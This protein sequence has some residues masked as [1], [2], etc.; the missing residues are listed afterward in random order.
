[1]KLPSLNFL[2]TNAGQSFVRFPLSILA[3]LAS[4][5]IGVYLVEQGYEWEDTLPYLN[6]ML[7]LGLGIPVYFCINVLVAKKQWSLQWQ[8]SLLLLATVALVLLYFTFPNSSDTLNNTL[9]YTRYII[10]NIIAHLLVAFIPYTQRHQLNGFWNYN[11]I[12]FLRFLTSILYSSVL[13][14]GLVLA[15]ASLKFLFD[16]ELHEELFAD[17]AICIFGF[18][19]TWFFVAGIPTDFD[20]LNTVDQYP[21]GLRIF[22]Q[23]ILLPLLCLYFVI[24]YGYGSKIIMLWNWPKGLVSYL[25]LCVAVL[26]IFTLLLLYPYGNIKAFDWIKKLSRGYY[27]LLVPLIVLLFIA[28]SFRLGDY[29]ITINRYIILFLG[30]WLTMVSIYF[31]IGKTDIRFI[32][33]SLSIMLFLMSFGPWGMFD[34][35]ERS[36]VNRL[37][38]ILTRANILK[39]GRIENEVIWSKNKPFVDSSKLKNSNEGLMSDSIHNEVMSIYDYLNTHH[40]FRA[41]RP[42]YVQNIDSLI[43]VSNKGKKRWERTQENEAYMESAGLKHEYIYLNNQGDFFNYSSTRDNV[44]YVEDYQYF[45]SFNIAD[46]NQKSDF[47]IE[48]DSFK[49]SLESNDK[50]FFHSKNRKT[51][52]PLKPFIDSIIN[53]YGQES[54]YDLPTSTLTFKTSSNSWD[55]KIEFEEI[56]FENFKDSLKINTLNGNLYLKRK[57]AK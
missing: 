19:N 33:I 47:K 13:Y 28:I 10:Y 17:L 31:A 16:V 54:K 49:L 20:Q 42:W 8:W 40:G 37:E 29:G 1:M 5:I 35:S 27:F 23:Y 12:L 22:S 21:K 34:V 26:G 18:F 3:S 4:A 51:L 32:P 6:A 11:K 36:Q 2:F 30:I 14:L 24:L 39:N 53:E 56:Y 46:Y 15:L 44:K 48:S 50:L 38:A 52:L 7:C 57:V 45:I 9:P 41:I 55:F 25:I 43:R